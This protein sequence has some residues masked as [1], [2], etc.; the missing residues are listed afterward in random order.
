MNR[1]QGFESRLPVL[2]TL[3][4]F[5]GIAEDKVIKRLKYEH[6]VFDTA[7]LTA[8]KRHAEIS[9]VRS[10][11]YC[12]AYWRYGFHEDGVMSAQRVV[13]AVKAAC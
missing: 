6:P 12:G 7:M 4:D 3:N 13:D 2:V 11:H 5:G 9:G 8:Q 10:T 1:L